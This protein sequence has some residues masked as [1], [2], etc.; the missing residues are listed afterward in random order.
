LTTG[1]AVGL[2]LLISAVAKICGRRELAHFLLPLA[3]VAQIVFSV[4]TAGRGS[5]PIETSY[6][7]FHFRRCAGATN[8][9]NRVT[10][11]L[12]RRNNAPHYGSFCTTCYRRVKQGIKPGS[13]PVQEEP[14][15][16]DIARP[17]IAAVVLSYFTLSR[18]ADILLRPLPASDAASQESVAVARRWWWSALRWLIG[19]VACGPFATWLLLNSVTLRDTLC[20]WRNGMAVAYS[21]ASGQFGYAGGRSSCNRRSGK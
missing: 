1:A 14:S 4:H 10:H 17:P 11:W 13:Q 2:G 20:R 9:P 16:G 8:C 15:Q 6:G 5:E 19:I 18:Y 7:A 12:P 21:H 3:M